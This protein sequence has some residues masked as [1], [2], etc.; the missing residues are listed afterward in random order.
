MD[1]QTLL[2]FI[3]EI[4]VLKNIPRIG[5]QFRGI[6]NCE[7]VAD[8]CYR[9]SLLAML[10]ADILVEQGVRLNAE[11][12]MRIALLHE[13]A[14]ARVTDIPAVSLGYIPAEVKS[15]A[16]QKAA[17]AMLNPFGALGERYLALWEEFEQR[18]TLEARVVRTADKLEML[19]QAYQ[20]E[21]TGYQSLG[22]FWDRED[23]RRAFEAFPQF[24]HILAILE[25]RRDTLNDR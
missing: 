17:E 10:L 22:D 24:E 8:H 12:V 1:V 25:A 20:Y 18:S 11:K 13:I 9:V 4:G 21:K 5:W 16:E 15:Q 19:I 6:K 7:S 2:D 3:E 23:T 14:E